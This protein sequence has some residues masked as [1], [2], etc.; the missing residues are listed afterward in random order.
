MISIVKSK[1]FLNHSKDKFSVFRKKPINVKYN[2]MKTCLQ[3]KR[4]CFTQKRQE[5]QRRKGNIP[6][7]LCLS[8]RLCVKQNSS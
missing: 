4:V 2:D 7:R 1:N 5:R 8:W 3:V 6:L